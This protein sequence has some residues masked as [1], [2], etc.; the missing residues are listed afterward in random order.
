MGHSTVATTRPYRRPGDAARRRPS[1]LTAGSHSFPHAHEDHDRSQDGEQ[2]SGKSGPPQSQRTRSPG[3]PTKSCRRWPTGPTVRWTRSWCSFG[4]ASANHST[5]TGAI[6]AAL[7]ARTRA[8]RC[9]CCW[10]VRTTASASACAPR[11][12]GSGTRT[13]ATRPAVLR[14]RRH[15][16]RRDADASRS[17]AAAWVRR[18]RRPAFLRLRTVRL[19]GHAG[20][21]VEAAYRRPAEIAADE[22]SDP[23]LGTARL[24]VGTGILTADEVI[25]IYE[26]KRRGDGDRR[27]GRG[28]A[29]AVGRRRDGAAGPAL[30]RTRWPP[31]PGWPRRAAAAVFDDTLPST[32]ALTLT[33]SINRALA[34]YWRPTRRRWCSARTSAARAACTG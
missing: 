3:S 5:A 27:R 13:G 12:A 22:D 14:R 15:G 20:S 21:D 17:E 29:A 28:R 26:D 7:H 18:R 2:L 25:E 8:C 23:L 32:R 4:D 9:R 10:S 11:T 31:R 33:Q 16:P 6:N 19:M 24:L 1:Q 30:P 34:T